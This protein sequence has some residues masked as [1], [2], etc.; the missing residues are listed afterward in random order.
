[1]RLFGSGSLLD[2]DTRSWLND[3]ARWAVTSFGGMRQIEETRLVLPTIEF[4]S[5]NGETGTALAELIFAQTKTHAGMA[6]W[7][8]RLMAQPEAPKAEIAP[9]LAQQFHTAAPAGTFSIDKADDG[10]RALITY[11]PA[12]QAKPMALVATFA[13]ELAHYLILSQEQPPPGG[14]EM[15]EPA[16]DFMAVFMGFGVFLAISQFEFNQF[17]DGL[18]Q[19]WRSQRRG[20]LGETELIFA[21]AQFLTLKNTSSAD[22]INYLKPHMRSML[23]RAMKELANDQEWRA[24]IRA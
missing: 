13:H 18:A 21:L 9:T 19:G 24:R 20:Y 10:A 12:D 17:Q 23:K 1:M 6:D 22:A 14:W 16:T 2:P 4:F 5:A 3:A 15:H 8:C 11:H 7:P